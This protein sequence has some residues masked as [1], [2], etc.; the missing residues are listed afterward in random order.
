MLTFEEGFLMAERLV[1]M[2]APDINMAV[3]TGDYGIL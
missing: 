2:P 3:V 1:G